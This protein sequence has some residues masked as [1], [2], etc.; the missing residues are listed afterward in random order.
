MR[1]RIGLLPDAH[2][3]VDQEGLAVNMFGFVADQKQ[4][5]AGTDFWPRDLS[6]GRMQLHPTEC[7][8]G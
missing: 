7:R 5:G 6:V 2:A 8:I 1:N 3:A 4:C